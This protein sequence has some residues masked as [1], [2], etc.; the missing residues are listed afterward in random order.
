MLIRNTVLE[1]EREK[2]DFILNSSLLGMYID[3]TQRGKGLAS[4]CMAIWLQLCLRAKAQPRTEKI[5]KPLLSLVL[6][7]FGFLPQEGGIK[8]EISPL[9]SI[10]EKPPS[11]PSGWV[12]KLA[13]YSKDL[14]PLDGSFGKRELRTQQMMITREPPCPRGT[15]TTV[16]TSFDHPISAYSTTST[17]SCAQID[18]ESNINRVLHGSLKLDT[19]DDVLR[20]VLF[21]FCIDLK[22]G[23]NDIRLSKKKKNSYLNSSGET[24]K[25]RR[26]IK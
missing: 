12:P 7:K 22:R 5:N 23:S 2:G 8:V 24:Y 17:I 4:I 10:K 14:K 1:G 26:R 15:V 6:C 21:G 9:S 20:R 25:K 11:Y 18:L 16:K 13:M 19:S 3:E